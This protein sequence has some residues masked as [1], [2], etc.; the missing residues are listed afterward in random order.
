M[1]S[2]ENMQ[3]LRRYLTAVDS[4]DEA[5]VL[6][7]IDEHVAEGY[8]AHMAGSTLHGRGV[9]CQARRTSA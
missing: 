2:E 7:L 6:T 5:G 4:G 8:V 1:S 3:R 9:A